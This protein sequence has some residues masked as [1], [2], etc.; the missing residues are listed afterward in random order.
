MKPLIKE[1][2]ELTNLIT[3]IEDS[4]SLK[5]ELKKY[6]ILQNINQ[7]KDN[8][9]TTD[10]LICTGTALINNTLE[11]ILNKFKRR[12]QKIVLIG[13]TASM[14]PDILFDYGV[15]IVGGMEI[16]DSQAT[17]QVIQEGG[18]TQLF[19]KYGKKYNLI[20]E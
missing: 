2:S 9:L 7:L 20:K 10:I 13:P 15:D 1:I 8:E 18:G 19:K 3:I 5:P 4:L 12:A 6:K 16:L 11:E 17:I 14:I